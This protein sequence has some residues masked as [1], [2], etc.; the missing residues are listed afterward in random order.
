MTRDPYAEAR[1]RYWQ[2]RD[3][4]KRAGTWQGLV[5][6]EEAR[7]HVRELHRIWL[8]S[9]EAIAELAGISHTTVRHLAVGS[10]TRQLPPPAR[11]GAYTAEVLLTV[12][13]DDLPDNCLV[14][15]TGSMRRMRA[16]SVEGW[17]VRYIANQMDAAWDG[18][19]Q[20]RRGERTTVVLRTARLLRRTYDELILLDPYAHCRKTV[21]TTLRK[22]AAASGW[23][24]AAAWADAIDDPAAKPWHVVRCSYQT[25]INGSKDERLLCDTHLKLLK[26]RGTLEG[27]RLMRNTQA[28]LED[29]RFILATDPPINP[30]TQ[31]IDKERLA[32]RL[33]TNWEALERVLLRANI[34][35]GKLRESA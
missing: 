1:R 9:Y 13:V 29:A 28:L 6:A 11:V 20:L 10:A 26:K 12:T 24:P 27:A 5:D 19:K 17:P 15:A 23:Y 35:L 30:R 4:E 8:V 2:K 3:K 14:N 7:Q 16:L 34:N 32:E 25:C 22:Q 18:L 33:G 21:V 31:E